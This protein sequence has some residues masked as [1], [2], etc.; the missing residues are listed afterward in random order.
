V[1]DVMTC[2]PITTRPEMPVSEAAALMM[3][4][5]VGSLPVLE[6]DRL[7]GIITDRDAVKAL[8]AQVPALRYAARPLWE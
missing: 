1:K 2:S 3:E 6:Q 4:S 7:V 5:H 8:A